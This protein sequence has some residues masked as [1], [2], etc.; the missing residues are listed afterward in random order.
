[1]SEGRFS[2]D[3]IDRVATATDIVSIIG[4]YT[5][6][7]P[8]GGKL[9]GLCPFHNEKTP[10]FSVDPEQGLYYCFGCHVGGTVFT[11]I[12]EKEGLSFPEA[13]ESLARDAGIDLPKKTDGN[14][15]SEGLEEAAEN[16]AI[17]F[18][19]AL[20]SK[21]GTE[22]R[23]YL[24]SR[25]VA[26]ATWEVFALGWA[27]ADQL[28][29]AKYLKREK[30]KEKAFLEQGLLG[31]SKSENKFF[32]AIYDALVFPIQKTNG[33]TVGFAQRKIRE[34]DRSGP[35][36]I[37]SADNDIY[38]KSS[39][40]Y[41]LPQARAAIRKQGKS[42]LV[43]GY[44]DVIGLFEH[45]IKNAVGSCGTA[46]T[47]NQASILARYAPRV[48]VLFDGDSAG[49]RAT[50]RSIE[51]LLSAGLDVFICRLPED[52]DP[53]SFVKEKGADELLELLD[54]SP[55]WFD[56]LYGHI[57]V[58]SG[59]EGVA[60]SKLLI[61][62]MSNAIHSIRDGLSRE[63]YIRKLAELAAT[64]EEALRRH[65]RTNSNRRHEQPKIT[66]TE[67]EFVALS[68]LAKL[69]LA[70]L[71]AIVRSEK[72]FETEENPLTLYPGL[73]EIAILR[74][75]PSQFLEQIAES[76]SRNCLAQIFL[77][78][79]PEDCSAHANQLLSKISRMRIDKEIETLNAQLRQA[80]NKG[81]L[82]LQDEI[83][84]KLS[85]LA[86]KLGGMFFATNKK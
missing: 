69:E 71:A 58:N 46:L 77:E 86:G 83:I 19:K 17:F 1:M 9:F 37:N 53:D 60:T 78:P 11:F 14:D 62:G 7:K 54:S 30:K 75:A 50:L 33:R 10:S 85:N 22:A 15:R 74:P 79:Q 23:E 26:E 36:Y 31:Q 2:R 57:L 80:E 70:L 20:K 35:K 12:M 28:M 48:V 24:K 49:L 45:G 76:R 38:H 34:S 82:V 72:V 65:L 56:W 5:S 39:I 61:E 44:F 29:F 47:S 52:E 40:L 13:V 66:E 3:F 18:A 16:A 6:L 41:G 59:K 63:I 8:R 32:A 27:P 81:D 4:R 73:W 64:S 67:R 51:I 43:E 84:K 55:N 68:Q 42:I 25:G 21:L